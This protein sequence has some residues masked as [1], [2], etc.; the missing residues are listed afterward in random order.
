M[1]GLLSELRQQVQGLLFISE[2]ESLLEPF[3]LPMGTSAQTPSD[4]L[5]AQGLTSDQPVEQ[6]TVPY[7]FR[8]MVREDVAGAELAQ[9]FTA[10]VQ[11]LES[12][13]QELTVY[14]LGNVQVQAYVVG[15]AENDQWLG[16][17]TTL[18]E[19]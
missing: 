3:E 18:V 15:K 12:N 11:W 6:V 10:L 5:S 1:S 7:F 19:T 16:L 9:G 14:R 13:L 4:F 8:N 17:K 2:S